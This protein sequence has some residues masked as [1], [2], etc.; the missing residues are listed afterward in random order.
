MKKRYGSRV[1]NS[2]ERDR[3]GGSGLNL[4]KTCLAFVGKFL[5]PFWIVSQPTL[6]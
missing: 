4:L 1:K 3:D 2:R 5:A 6:V